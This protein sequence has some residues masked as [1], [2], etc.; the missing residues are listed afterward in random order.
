M[1]H[2]R[3]R[4]VCDKLRETWNVFETSTRHLESVDL[5]ASSVSLRQIVD[6]WASK[7]EKDVVVVVVA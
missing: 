7:E 6:P 1:G 4:K 2:D 5:C 3:G